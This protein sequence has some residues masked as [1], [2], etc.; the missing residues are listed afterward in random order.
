[1]SLEVARFTKPPGTEGWPTTHVRCGAAGQSRACLTNIY[2][3]SPI[4]GASSASAS[5]R[6][7]TRRVE[8]DRPEQCRF[9]AIMLDPAR[10]PVHAQ[11]VH[12]GD[13][14]EAPGPRA[15]TRMKSTS[16]S[17][18]GWARAGSAPPTDAWNGASP[19]DGCCPTFVAVVLFP[20]PR[21]ARCAPRFADPRVP[22]LDIVTGKLMC[23][24]VVDSNRQKTV[25]EEIATVE[26]TL[27]PPP[28]PPVPP[29]NNIS[30]PPLPVR[31]RL[32]RPTR[33]RAP[34]PARRPP[35]HRRQG[36]QL[37][38]L[39]PPQLWGDPGLM[40]SRG[41]GCHICLAVVT[42]LCPHG[43]LE[44]FMEREGVPLSP[45]SS[46]TSCCRWRRA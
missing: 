35:I 9:L 43:N 40:G 16:A 12:R 21:G 41:N 46:S 44:D 30:S 3:G 14:R 42:E 15:S 25:V 19:R 2:M 31:K 6:R 27:A 29:R 22:E 10:G 36:F 8:E 23:A 39:Q 26:G 5:E 11:R 20:P 38:Q 37:H 1:M 28:P 34:P 13:R 4:D 32:N 17:T 24:R 18:R 7:G 45:R 33:V